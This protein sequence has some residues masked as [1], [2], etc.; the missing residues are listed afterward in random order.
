MTKRQ[1]ESERGEAG[2]TL[3]LIYSLTTG[4]SSHVWLF[5]GAD[6]GKWLQEIE[7]AYA[8]ENGDDASFS[9]THRVKKAK[10]NN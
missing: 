1:R 3:R 8:A 4:S 7:K 5:K 2:D 10:A 9:H 6:G